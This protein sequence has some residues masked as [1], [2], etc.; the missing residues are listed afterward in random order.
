MPLIK[1]KV[2]DIVL[3]GT[4]ISGLNFIDKYLEKKVFYMLYLQRK[5]RKKSQKK[6]MI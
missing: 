5:Q 6:N 1:P 4:G 3:I 2:L